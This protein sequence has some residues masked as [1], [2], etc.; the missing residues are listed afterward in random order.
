MPKPKAQ[1]LKPEL[2]STQS[3]VSCFMANKKSTLRY[4]KNFGLIIQKPVLGF[5]L[6]P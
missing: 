1:S 6:K 5:G 2:N 3:E 4:F